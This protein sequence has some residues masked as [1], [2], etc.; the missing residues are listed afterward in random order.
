MIQPDYTRT[1]IDL[2]TAVT[3][4]RLWV[5]LGWQDVKRRYRRTAIGPFWSTLSLGIFMLTL[6]I[7]WSRLWKQDIRGYLPFLCAGMLPWVLMSSIVTEACSVFTGNESIIKS[8]WFSFTV[9]SCVV[10]WRNLIVL[11]HNAVIFLVIAVICLVPVT[12]NTFLVIPGLLLFCLNALWITILLGMVCS[13]Y[14]DVAPLVTSILQIAMFVTP[15]FWAPAQLGAGRVNA[16]LVDFNPIYHFIDMIRSP[17]LGNAPT[18]WTYE[19][20]MMFTVFG[21]LGTL[22][23]FSR[24]ARRI[25]FW[26]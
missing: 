23:L 11:G 25:A 2:R 26:I 1:E 3:G 24:F 8:M 14:R 7:L 15:I 5:R 21:W 16:V 9:L 10:V 17:L 12:A 18:L 20:V 22:A 13:R 6:G 4:W 19:A